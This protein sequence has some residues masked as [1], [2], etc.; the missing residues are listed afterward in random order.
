MYQLRITGKPPKSLK[1]TIKS[2]WFPL[3]VAKKE[4]NPLWNLEGFLLGCF[5]G[6]VVPCKKKN[7]MFPT[8]LP[9]R[10]G[11]P[12]CPPKPLVVV[13]LKGPF[14]PFANGHCM[15]IMSATKKLGIKPRLI[16]PPPSELEINKCT[17]V[18]F[19]SPIVISEVQV[20]HETV[21]KGKGNWK[22]FPPIFKL[23]LFRATQVVDYSYQI[24]IGPTIYL[25][26][27]EK[28]KHIHCIH[29]CIVNT[30]LK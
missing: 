17:C 16:V 10:P 23:K 15:T 22:V 2:L 20:F 13:E 26:P 3:G 12:M 8:H 14:F 24:S 21:S 4:R 7:R 1:Y 5:S 6:L 18:L 11:R 25:F 27:R 9:T 28:C 29:A 19:N 30:L